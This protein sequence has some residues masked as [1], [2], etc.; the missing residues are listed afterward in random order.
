MIGFATVATPTGFLIGL[1]IGLIP[2]GVGIYYRKWR[3]GIGGYI[4]CVAE[5]LRLRLPRRHSDD[6]RDDGRRDFLR[7][8]QSA[9]PFHLA[10]GA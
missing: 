10:G 6:D 3:A 5:R 2:L 1:I 7:L 4:A 9:R 8:C